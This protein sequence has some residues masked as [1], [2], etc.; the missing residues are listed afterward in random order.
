MKARILIDAEDLRQIA[1]QFHC[2]TYL[3]AIREGRRRVVARGMGFLESG[4]HFTWGTQIL[5]RRMQ[6]QYVE[7]G[8]ETHTYIQEELRVQRAKA[9]ERAE[10]KANDRNGN[11]C[12][13]R[14]SGGTSQR[15]GRPHSFYP[16]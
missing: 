2:P 10:K 6:W 8:T 15:S 4:R 13:D 5:T 3:D 14:G 7:Y 9:K 11:N 1:V 12:T 16:D